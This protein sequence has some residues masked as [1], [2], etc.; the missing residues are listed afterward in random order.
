MLHFCPPRAKPT[1]AREAEKDS[2][3]LPLEKGC[4]ERGR[5]ELCR[6]SPRL[7]PS[8]EDGAVLQQ[9]A[10]GSVL[11]RGVQELEMLGAAL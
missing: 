11:G 9:I 7:G 2:F 8:P 6:G 5:T 10:G 1:H 3:Y 4:N